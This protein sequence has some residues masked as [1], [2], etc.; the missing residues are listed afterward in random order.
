L[1]TK[2]EEFTKLIDDDAEFEKEEAWLADCQEAFMNFE[3]HGKKHL[4]EAAKQVSEENITNSQPSA[5]ASDTHNENNSDQTEN[6]NVNLEQVLPDNALHVSND[7]STGSQAVATGG[8]RYP[9]KTAHADLRWKNQ[10]YLNFREMYVS[11]R[12]FNPILSTLLNQG[13]LNV[14]L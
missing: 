10:N 8:E 12:Y 3:I 13:T 4:D 5:S 1:V 6:N 9:L 11:T 7:V 2:H 14:M